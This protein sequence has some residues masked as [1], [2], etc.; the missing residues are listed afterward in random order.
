MLPDLPPLPLLCIIVQLQLN[1][2]N[3]V[4]LGTRLTVLHSIDFSNKVSCLC[5]WFGEISL[6][7]PTCV[8]VSGQ[9]LS[10]V[11]MWVGRYLAT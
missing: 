9:G 5:S 2:K 7:T 4:V 10:P 11:V 3:W 1:D 8:Y 6:A